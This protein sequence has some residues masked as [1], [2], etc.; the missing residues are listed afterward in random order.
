MDQTHANVTEVISRDRPFEPNRLSPATPLAPL[1]FLQ[2]Q[3]RGSIT[4]PSLHAAPAQPLPPL[5]AAISPRA[6]QPSLR[7]FAAQDP[8][9]KNIT[10]PT[11][12]GSPYNLG[13]A[14]AHSSKPSIRSHNSPN[15][16]GKGSESR[17][18]GQ[19]CK[20]RRTDD[21][22][23]TAKIQCPHFIIVSRSLHKDRKSVV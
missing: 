18:Y 12:P 10:R 13:E 22:V 4:D 3:R 6:S 2:N 19:F 15:E 7:Q 8:L 21:F 5:S 16:R 23:I 9:S 1:E 14:S 20:C 11:R 17:I